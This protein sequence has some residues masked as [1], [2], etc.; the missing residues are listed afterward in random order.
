MASSDTL[1][2]RLDAEFAATRERIR[3]MQEEANRFS[4]KTQTQFQV[5]TRLRERI[6]GLTA[7][8]LKQLQERLPGAATTSVPSPHGGSVSLRL[9]SGLARIA[10]GLSLSHDG[11]LGKAFLDYDLE[12]LPILIRFEHHSRLE[13]PLDPLDCDDDQIAR[14]LDDRIVGFVHTYMEVQ[15]T[16]QYQGDNMVN[17]PVAHISFPKA[18]GQSS[19]ERDGKTYHFLSEQTRRE[20]EG[21][22]AAYTSK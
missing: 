13:V 3:G 1:T 14:W 15:F 16:R 2:G 17:D 18:F 5:F 11:P 6:D 9:E 10:L 4:E 21:G 12:I 7:P 22:P 8:R 20:F 19:L